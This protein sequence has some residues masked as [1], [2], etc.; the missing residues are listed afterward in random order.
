M[1]NKF[2]ESIAFRLL[3]AVVMFSLAITLF[4]ACVSLYF[5]YRKEMISLENDFRHI[6]KVELQGMSETLWV[7]NTELLR[8]SLNGFL[9]IG[10]IKYAAI[11]YKERLIV[12]AG[13]PQT[14]KSV[15]R[16]FPLYYTYNDRPVY[17][18]TLLLTASLKEVYDGLLANMAR[19]LLYQGIQVFL[20][21]LFMLVVFQFF[22]TRHLI[23]MA[24]YFRQEAPWE[25]GRPL[26]L[27]GYTSADA[28]KDEIGQV[29]AAINTMGANMRTAFH[30]LES[31]L[32]KRRQAEEALH[33]FR[34]LIDQ[35]NDAIFVTDPETGRFLDV[36]D[37]ACQSLG[38]TRDELLAMGTRNLVADIPD[39]FSWEA[40]VNEL[41]QRGY[42]LSEDMYKRKDGTRFPVEVNVKYITAEKGTYLLAVVRDVTEKKNL[43]D[44]LRHAQK[45]EA[46]GTLAGGVAHDFNNILS[47][48][49]G[50]A[51]LM[52]MKSCQ[53]DPNIPH[54]RE[55]L[56]A[57]ERAT[58][59]TQSLL[60]FSRKQ[61]A[62]LKP[63]DVNN[64]VDGVKKMVLRII[65]EDIETA[66]QLHPGRLMVMGDC[67]Q[68]EQV[69]MNFVT[70]ARDAMP[71][72]G[73]L[74]IT[75]G[76]YAL[77][78]T[79]SGLYGQRLHGNFAVISVSDTGMGMDERTRER[80][81][82]PFFTTKVSGKGTGL[83]LA[84]VYGIVKQ[85]GGFID[86]RSK[87]GKGTTFEVYLPI[88]A[89]DVR[90]PEEIL[91]PP[92]QG[93]TETILVADDDENIR[94]LTRELLEAHGYSVIEANDG[95]DAIDR[96]LQN[97]G[98]VQLLLFD[99][100]MPRLSGAEAFAEISRLSPGM[101]VLFISGY[102][103]D[104]LERKQL[105]GEELPLIGKPMRPREL[106]S[107]IREILDSR[108]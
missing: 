9:N 104:T 96:F 102:A 61:P 57:A 62:E 25:F 81:F 94:R 26:V 8:T 19:R 84:I 58:N 86:C 3:F 100:I 69:L 103:A 80:I 10:H 108:E 38:Y 34:K 82:E 63:V 78:G 24:A 21:T 43:E 2:R 107:K 65:G 27:A 59:L 106:L 53:T 7:M 83:G 93:G 97:R 16:Q 29:A 45:L 87:P 54:I 101:K 99:V 17:I 52:E 92:V 28:K 22:V 60:I 20:I 64:M 74:T 68:L 6:E 70:N 14:E 41:R 33:L 44:Q 66:I 32:Q 76:L 49:V 15:Q 71:D 88:V 75:T 18:G 4:L 31:E 30:E 12:S 85:H 77:D 39:D 67:G 72:G 37:K 1:P 90:K 36:N 47:A 40:H 42:L 11:R 23:T 55:I 79:A 89:A 91:P 13:T 56:A 5:D 46:L 105:L 48:I 95:L 98:R 73:A 50:Y 51:G 35:S